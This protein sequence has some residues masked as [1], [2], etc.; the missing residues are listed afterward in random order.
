MDARSRCSVDAE[1]LIRGLVARGGPSPAD[2]ACLNAALAD[3]FH[4]SRGEARP[5]PGLSPL[6]QA[7]GEA[8]SP[9]TLQGFAWRKPHGY[10]GDFE[11][12]DRIYQGYIAPSPHLWRWDGFFQSTAAARAVR[13][14]KD[15]FHALLRSC[16]WSAGRRLRVLNVASGPGRDM[17]EY[18]LAH[19]PAQVRFDCIDQDAKA[20]AYAHGL[21]EA[22]PHG[23]RFVQG[24]V[25]TFRP[26]QRYDLVWCA[27]LF[28][29]FDD[30]IFR[31]M[32]PRLLAAVAPQGQLVI[33]NFSDMNPNRPY[34]HLM[35]WELYHRSADQLLALA[36][37]CGIPADRLRVGQEPEGVNLFLHVSA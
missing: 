25:L 24:S 29:Y 2:Y 27:G 23:V 22:F 36:R 14:R 11:I 35:E 5:G 17:R 13:N 30:R 26:E 32:L 6:R 15:Y 8:L 33:G 1:G 12:I 20:I 16:L 9:Q 37:Q 21:C 19:G 34:L 31:R 3:A 4:R 7:M 10:A 18:F 28:D